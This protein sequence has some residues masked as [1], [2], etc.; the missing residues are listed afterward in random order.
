MMPTPHYCPSSWPTGD[1][2]DIRKRLLT[3]LNTQI[4][5]L[6]HNS[7]RCSSLLRHPNALITHDRGSQIRLQSLHSRQHFSSLTSKRTCDR[8][9]EMSFLLQIITTKQLKHQSFRQRYGSHIRPTTSHTMANTFPEQVSSVAF[10]TRL[11]TATS[12]SSLPAPTKTSR[13]AVTDER[14]EWLSS[15]LSFRFC[16]D[17]HLRRLYGTF[18]FPDLMTISDHVMIQARVFLWSRIKLQNSGYR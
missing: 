9:P 3:Y 8:E 5:E 10:I 2:Y 12:V 1:Q 4:L 18:W 7:N 17:G 11:C 6:I 15:R 16:C 14:Q 13:T